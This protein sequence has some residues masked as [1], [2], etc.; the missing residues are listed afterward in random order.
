MSA[1]VECSSVL[2]L[3]LNDCPGARVARVIGPVYGTGVSMCLCGDIGVKPVRR[4][5]LS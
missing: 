4:L 2:V 5:R 1:S 3:T